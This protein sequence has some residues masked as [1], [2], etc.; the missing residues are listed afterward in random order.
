MAGRVR[1]GGGLRG[2][3]LIGEE[4]RWS[5][6]EAG[7]RAR[8]PLMVLGLVGASRSGGA[9]RGGGADDGTARAEA[10]RRA[11]HPG[12]VV[13]VG[14]QAHACAA[15]G[16]G[17]MLCFCLS[18]HG[19]ELRAAGPGSACS[20]AAWSACVCLREKK[21]STARRLACELACRVCAA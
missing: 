12:R 15:R 13:R 5:A 8:R 10:E 6:V 2:G 7:R 14:A 1:G 11:G 19:V 9:I 3:L 21:V 16:G 18:V 4:R 20:H 17:A